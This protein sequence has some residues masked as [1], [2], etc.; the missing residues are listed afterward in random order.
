MEW[1]TQNPEETIALGEQIVNKF[2]E[3]TVIGIEGPLGSGKTH[4]VK[5]M[6]LALG[7]P[8]DMIKSPTFL[9]LMEHDGVRRLLHFDFYRHQPAAGGPA[10]STLTEWWQEHLNHP[11][12]L[13]V[14]E[15]PEH[16]PHAWPSEG[17]MRLQM[18]SLG[19]TKRRI[20][21]LPN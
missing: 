7:L 9:T 19:E 6:G 10:L 2:P 5:G 11:N 16:I 4:L 1:I 15:W 13:V 14:V 3:I 12:A 18:E 21:V 17:A 8:Q 20:R